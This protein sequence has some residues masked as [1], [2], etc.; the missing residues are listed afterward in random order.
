MLHVDVPFDCGWF[1]LSEKASERG[2]VILRPNSTKT[3][4]ISVAGSFI[5][6]VILSRQYVPESRD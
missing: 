3:D 6:K 2:I 4:I 1:C 5:F